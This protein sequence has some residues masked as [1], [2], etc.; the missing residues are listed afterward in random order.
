MDSEEENYEF[1]LDSLDPSEID[2]AVLFGDHRANTNS[3]TLSSSSDQEDA[4]FPVSRRPL[5]LQAMD[6]SS[7]G[8]PPVSVMTPADRVSAH[9]L[10]LPESLLAKG[11]EREK[12]HIYVY[13]KFVSGLGV[14]W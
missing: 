3:P 11:V 7:V 14:S 10:P 5:L 12:Y 4:L 8:R 13:I 1:N 6:I 2:Q 9:D